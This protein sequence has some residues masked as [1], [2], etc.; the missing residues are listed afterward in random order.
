MTTPLLPS[1]FYDVLAPEA[2]AEAQVAETI[3]AVLADYGYGR[4]APP[5]M[6]FEE[7]LLSGPGAALNRATF[8]VMDTAS[9]RMLGLRTD[10]TLQIGRLAAT[11]LGMAPRPLRLSYAGAVLRQTGDEQ[12]PARELRQVGAELI[13][14]MAAEADA[15]AIRLAALALAR[16]GIADVS[17]DIVLPTLVPSLADAE[18]L[19]SAAATQLA[20]ALAHKDEA[21]VAALAKGA[22]GRVAAIALGFLRA[23]GPAREAAAALEKAD[24]PEKAAADRT[25]LLRVLDLL[26]KDFTPHLTVD[27]VERRYFEYQ[28]GLSFTFYEKARRAELGRG[29]R[30][31]TSAGE[32]ATGFTFYTGTIMPVLPAAA[33]RPRLLVPQGLTPGDAQKL[34]AQGHALVQ[35]LEGGGEDEARAQ[36]CTA[37]Y[38]N[39]KARNL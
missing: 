31:R 26:G 7:T 5:L 19:D 15:E 38:E 6:E 4:V 10:H 23:S 1:G 21:A 16:L 36:G 13:G 33:A 9:Q 30:Y 14:S 8:R 28:T 22:G 24:L 35:A 20:H 17:V 39:G 27:L 25:R 3:L 29:G 37:L 11:R 34:I 18:G 12:N 32:P 2:A